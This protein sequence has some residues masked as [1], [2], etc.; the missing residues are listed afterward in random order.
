MLDVFAV[1]VQ[2][3][4]HFDLTMTASSAPSRSSLH[5]ARNFYLRILYLFLNKINLYSCYFLR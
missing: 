1:H 4:V 2:Y 5:T 3:I